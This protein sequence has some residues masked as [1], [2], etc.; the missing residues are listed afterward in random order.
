MKLLLTLIV[1]VCSAVSSVASC[2]AEGLYVYPSGS[3]IK[4]NSMF[5]VR[6]YAK[7]QSVVLGLNKKH[8]IYLRSGRTIV[9]L[10]VT[11]ICV[12][13]Y[14]MTQAILKPERELDDGREYTV[15]IDSLPRHEELERISN[16]SE[17]SLAP[18]YRVV[19]GKDDARP[20]VT[21]KPVIMK[22]RHTQYGCGPAIYVEFSNPAKDDSEIWVKTT[23]RSLKSGKEATYYL[24]PEDEKIYVGL[25]MCSGAF[26]FRDDGSYEVELSFM[27]SCGN[28]TAWTGERMV[29]TK[30]EVGSDDD[31]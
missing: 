12:G 6:G 5:I 23:V 20:E 11:E 13:Q 3:T 15:I 21:A 7:S 30:P 27:D 9:R 17:N 10:V 19:A 8:N 25:S 1:L 26:A 22:K 18:S 14:K 31:D 24:V 2:T 4:Q 16:T 29:F 28:L